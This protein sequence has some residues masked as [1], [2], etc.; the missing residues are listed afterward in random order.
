MDNY[1]RKELLKSMNQ[2]SIDMPGIIY[3]KYFDKLGDKNKYILS[4]ADDAYKSVDVFCYPMQHVALSQAAAVLRQLLEQVS[5]ITILTNDDELLKKY[6]EHFKFRQTNNSLS[7]KKL[8][9]AVSE[10]FGIE[11][12]RFALTYLDYGWMK[13][14]EG[15]N[16]GEDEMIRMAGFEDILY[17]RKTF[18]D[19]MAH[20]AYT[21]T[22]FLVDDDFPIM[23]DL[24]RI[25]SKLFDYLC[26]A[27]HNLTG[28]DFLFDKKDL[29][30]EEFRQLYSL[31]FEKQN[32]DEKASNISEEVMKTALEAISEYYEEDVNKK[33]NK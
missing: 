14:D 16:C 3:N 1:L 13:C 27:F 24:I 25:A 26:V 28:F 10:H 33:E 31:C 22:N 8:I 2:I 23:D 5:I 29:F 7:R 18:L 15:R 32:K 4:M 6:I 17:W 19:K 11:N 21:S 12:N 20:A 30:N 9:D